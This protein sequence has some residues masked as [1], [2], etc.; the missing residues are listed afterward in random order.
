MK[1]LENINFIDGKWI[2]GN[3]KIIG[4]LSHGSWMGSPVF[5]G[6]RCFDG[7]APD[8]NEHCKRIIKS[9]KAMLMKPKIT[10]EEIFELSLEGIK[11]FGKKKDI[12]IRPLIWA[13]DSMG[14]LRCDPD[15]TRF[16][17]SII[18]MPM[19]SDKGF[20]ACTSKYTRPTKLSAPTDAKAACLYP[21]G[22]RAMNEAYK[23]G[24]ENAVICDPFGKI[25][26]FASSN[27]FIVKD[28]V[29]FTPKD[30][31]TYLAGIT[32][33]TIINL[34]KLNGIKIEE[35]DLSKDDLYSADEI[36][37]TGNFGKVMYIKKLDDLEFRAGK[38]F[39]KLN[40]LYTDY[41]K[42]FEI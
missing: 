34:C 17:L 8:L 3:K 41:S 40:K 35:T 22:A 28:D 31:G 42:N 1:Q 25:A 36:L 29:L 26:E 7:L 30:N 37:S 9:A 33:R 12:Y 2:K 38:M 39:K 20:T 6:A 11:K 5:D 23:K 15:S 32:R 14:L 4:P 18:N 10:S 19:P 24:Y 27:L 21:N 16:C 13:E